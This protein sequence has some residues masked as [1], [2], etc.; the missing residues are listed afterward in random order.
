LARALRD[1]ELAI[2]T[3][4]FGV[5]AKYIRQ[6]SE[7]QYIVYFGLQGRGA[8]ADFYEIDFLEVHTAKSG[9]AIALRYERNGEQLIHVVDAGYAS[10]AEKLIQHIE[11][12]F[13][14]S[15][16]IIDHLVVTHPDWDHAGGVPEIIEKMNVACVWMLR[17]WKY[18][19]Q[20]IHRFP[21]YSS[22]TALENKLRAAYPYI[23]DVEKA[24]DKKH[25]PI[26]EPFQGK[27][28]GAFAV[29]APSQARYFDLIVASDKTPDGE[30]SLG[31]MLG[32][33]ADAAGQIVKK[34]VNFIKSV[35]G[36][37]TFSTEET[38]VEN[39]MSVIQYALL[40][41][42]KIVLTGDAGRAG[43]KE[44]ADYAPTAGLFLP[45]LTRFQ[46]PHHGGRRNVSTELLDRWL[47]APLDK[48]AETPLFTA[49]I[50]AA[51]EDEDHPRK[52]VVRAIHHRGGKVVTTEQGAVSMF[53]NRPSSRGW[54]K[55]IG[56]P[57][58]DEQE[59]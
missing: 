7:T 58:P 15:D 2:T 9:D 31:E 55:A 32:A 57:Y 47:G 33:A 17:P 34:A 29:L 28:I 18:A 8:M 1:I 22:V 27:T 26:F 16:V 14:G 53:E 54:G 51:S 13:G 20:L 39:E 35:W 30:K 12:Y 41:G 50:S 24:A 59:E 25:I 45:G 40:S 23:A 42:H 43:L 49:V 37:E 52:S 56:T 48:P 21:T 5:V 11:N 10:T 19:S 4:S 36:A 6:S 3:T 38:S 46:V 44:A